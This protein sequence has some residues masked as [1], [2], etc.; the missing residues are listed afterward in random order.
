MAISCIGYAEIK[1][2]SGQM[3]NKEAKN[4]Q[5]MKEHFIEFWKDAN[6]YQSIDPTMFDIDEFADKWIYQA[7][8]MI[9]LEEE[10][11]KI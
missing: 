1:T 7:I 8:G 6:S 4:F 2:N 5:N 3:T 10:N 11:G 9:A